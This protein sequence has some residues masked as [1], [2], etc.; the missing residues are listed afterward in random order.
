MTSEHIVKSYDEELTKLADLAVQMGHFA[1]EQLLE[2]IAAVVEGDDGAC[3]KV[4]DQDALVNGLEQAVSAQAAKIVALRQPVAS[5]LRDVLSA[6]RISG[7]LE[8]ISDY[9]ANIAKRAMALGKMEPVEQVAAVPRLGNLAQ[10]LLRDVVDAYEQRDAGR[11][12]SVWMRDKELDEAH[13]AFFRGLLAG[14]AGGSL[15]I[16]AGTHLLFISKD[17]ERIGDHATNIAEAVYFMVL[18]ESLGQDRPKNDLS[19][20]MTGK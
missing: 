6:L 10:E 19:S 12:L 1:E 9:A 13:T 11:A 15:G 2:A 14:M 18:G 3:R 17:I 20:A 5:D 8:R 4:I 7:D 16:S